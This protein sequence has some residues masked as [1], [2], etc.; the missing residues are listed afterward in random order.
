M[1]SSF[2]GTTVYFSFPET[3][4]VRRLGESSRLVHW[5]RVYEV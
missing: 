5:G 1:T 2:P 4:V 3:T